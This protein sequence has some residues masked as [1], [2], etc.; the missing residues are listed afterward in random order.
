MTYLAG[1][2]AL[3]SG[4]LRGIGAAVVDRFVA[5]GAS[6]FVLDLQQA[7]SPA[8]EDL[9]SK[10]GGAVRY[11]QLDVTQEDGWHEVANILQ[12]EAG[13]LDVFVSNAGID[14]GGNVESLT[15]AYFHKVMDVN[16]AGMLFGVK[17]LKNLL[18]SRG[19][20]ATGG[21]SIIMVSSV[22][23]QIGLADAALYSASKGAVRAMSRALA[24]EFASAKI[25]IRVN[26]VFPGCVDTPLLMDTLATIAGSGK[27]GGLDDIINALVGAVPLG[28]LAQAREIANAILFLASCESSYI[29]GAEIVVDGGWT[30]Q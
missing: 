7:S 17:A 22:M 26:T 2:S 8:V 23:S 11:C 5:E 6:V 29:T 4:G 21:S 12:K 24:M 25:P 14:G 9:L 20:E 18:E 27:A 10:Y 15:S 13:G 3:V 19:R 16:V 28:R 30:A 1:R